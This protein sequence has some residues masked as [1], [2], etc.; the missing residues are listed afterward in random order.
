M[1]NLDSRKCQYSIR[2]HSW[3]FPEITSARSRALAIGGD[4]RPRTKSGN[5]STPGKVLLRPANGRKRSVSAKKALKKAENGAARDRSAGLPAST[6]KRGTKADQVEAAIRGYL[7]SG[8]VAPG[9]KIPLRGLANALGVSVMPVR[10]AVARLQADGAL[11]I[12]PGR[13]IRVPVMTASQFRELTAV[14]M[15][16]EGYAAELAAQSRNREDLARMADLSASFQLLGVRRS[17]RQYGAARINME[18]HFSVYRASKMPTLVDIIE[19]LWLKAGPAIFYFIHLEHAQ[20]QT[21]H[22]VV[23]HRQALE[24]IQRHDGPA[25]RA[26]IAEDIRLASERLLD[27]NV[28]REEREK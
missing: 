12:E 23:L 20:T 19:R 13:A 14:R 15:E 16:I 1:F 10:N 25:A 9:E 27:L 7:A 6:S 8:E 22:G 17:S 28:F 21:N 11:D 26:A 24:A 2:D 4:Q 3:G 5:R 18:F